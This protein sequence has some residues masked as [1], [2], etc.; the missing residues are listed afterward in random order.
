MNDVIDDILFL[1]GIEVDYDVVEKILA[2]IQRLD[3][4]GIGA[5]DLRETLIIQLKASLESST[6][7]LEAKELALKYWRTILIFSQKSTTLNYREF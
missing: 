6:E 5:K 4:V 1:Y 3:P 7:N 2:K